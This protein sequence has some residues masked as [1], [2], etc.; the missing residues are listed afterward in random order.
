[1]NDGMDVINFSGGGPEIDPSSDALI[2]ALDNVAAAGVVPVI[3]AGND[4]DDFGLGSV[5]SPSNAPVGDLGRRGLEPARLR[6]RADRHRRR[7]RRRA[8]STSRSPYNVARGA[9]LD[10]RADARRRRHDR[11]HRTA[12][13]SSATSARRPASTRTTRA[14]PRCPP[15]SLTGTV[16][17]VSRGGCTF[18][19]KAE[20]VCKAGATGIVLRRQPLRRGELHHR[21]PRLPGRD[22]LRPR[23]REPARRT[24]RPR[25]AARPSASSAVS[26]PKEI[27]TGRSG[28]ITSFSSAGP[29][30][31]RP[32]AEA[33]RRR[34]G[35]A[36]PLL[37]AD[38]VR[39]RAVRRLRRH[40]HGGAARL[41]RRRAAAAA[42]SR[43]VAAAGQVGAD[44]LGA[45]RVGRHRPHEGGARCCS[46]AAA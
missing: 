36:D 42:A 9:G 30:Q 38:R 3:S 41:R 1:M 4:R 12:S 27:D 31:L 11:R 2:D 8:C 44:D 7:A 46:R 18:A 34:A 35:R 23:R 26:D 39:G 40:E 28:I 24:S 15:G 43:L 25:A 45:A 14:T 29:D 33:R 21:R 20:R 17:L 16:A 22:D 5:G 13:R 6:Q 32:Q 10:R 19:S 37:D